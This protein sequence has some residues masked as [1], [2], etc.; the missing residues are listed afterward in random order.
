MSILSNTLTPA[1]HPTFPVRFVSYDSV[2]TNPAASSPNPDMVVDLI[3]SFVGQRS[4]GR[5]RRVS[6]QSRA[7][8]LEQEQHYP[9]TRSLLLSS[10]PLTPHETF[11]HPVGIVYAVST[12]TPDPLGTLAKLHAQTMGAMGSSVPWMDGINVLKLF[13]VVHDVSKMGEDLRP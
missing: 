6:W 9:L 11:N 7:H 2:F 1:I 12:S 4:P 3:S 5:S 13:V 10:R 8:V